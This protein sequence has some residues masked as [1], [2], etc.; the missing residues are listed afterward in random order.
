VIVYP[1]DPENGQYLLVYPDGHFYLG[2]IGFTPYSELIALTEGEEAESA[3]EGTSPDDFDREPLIVPDMEG[4]GTLAGVSERNGLADFY[5]GQWKDG[6]AEGEGIFVFQQLPDGARYVWY[7]TFKAGAYDAAQAFYG[8]SDLF[9]MRALGRETE[10]ADLLAELNAGLL[11]LQGKDGL[12]EPAIHGEDRYTGAF[13]N[14][15]LFGMLDR[16]EDE[17]VSMELLKRDNNSRSPFHTEGDILYLGRIR[18][19]QGT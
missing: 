4:L 17:R 6:L 12:M 11:G 7:G 9:L 18:L 14:M 2:S 19:R 15:D 16:G 13:A 8:S 1:V 10:E 5:I 3:E